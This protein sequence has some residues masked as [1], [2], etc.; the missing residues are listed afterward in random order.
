VLN[1]EGTDDLLNLTAANEVLGGS[2]LARINME[3]RERRG[4]SY[5]AFGGV[6]L[7]EH[8]SPY[9]IQ[10]PVQADRTGDSIAAV[11]QQVNAFLTNDGVRANELNR[12]ILG[13]TRQL[14]GQFETSPAVLGALRTN[15]LYDR[16]DNYWETVADRYRGM[17]QQVL[18]TTARQYID[19]DNFVWVVVGDAAVVR[20][21]LE[22][23]GL[24]I[25]VV[26]PQ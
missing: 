26:A 10:A 4:W 15:A 6:N 5:G 20:P 25:E 3:L 1:A 11:Q 24:P 16:P 17:T 7:F 19:A 12:N 22:R 13:N 21:Q 23:L 8:R 18:D 14:S 9:I 2:F